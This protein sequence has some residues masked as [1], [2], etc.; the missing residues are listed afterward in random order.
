[1]ETRLNG[2]I[3]GIFALLIDKNFCRR[4]NT[5]ERSSFANWD[6]LC[7]NGKKRRESPSER[8]WKIV[9]FH[10]SIRKNAIRASFRTKWAYT[11]REK[12]SRKMFRCMRESEVPKP[13]DSGVPPQNSFLCTNTDESRVY[14]SI[15]GF[16][17]TFLFCGVN[18]NGKNEFIKT[19]TTVWRKRS[20]KFRNGCCDVYHQWL[21]L[22]AGKSNWEELQDRKM[23][24]IQIEVGRSFGN[25]GERSQCFAEI[26]SLMKA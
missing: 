9:S 20:L 6:K 11:S 10:S 18:E 25:E 22:L 16:A 2:R 13:S 17:E 19:N 23:F 1:M 4:A 3:L 5:N 15:F 12:I 26:Q 14:W 21:I 7:D 8:G 24:E